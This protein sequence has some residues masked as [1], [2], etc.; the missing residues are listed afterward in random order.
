MLHCVDSHGSIGERPRA[1][2]VA[3]LE[4]DRERR[5]VSPTMERPAPI[6]TNTAVRRKVGV[7]GAIDLVGS[8]LPATSTE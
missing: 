5:V 1:E 4:D 2:Q 8:T 6:V 3:I 7:F